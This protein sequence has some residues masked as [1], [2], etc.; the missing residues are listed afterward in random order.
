MHVYIKMVDQ[1]TPVRLTKDPA[2]EGFPAWSPDGK[3]LAFLRKTSD[4]PLESAII[5]IPAIGGFERDLGRIHVASK[6]AWSPDGKWIAIADSSVVGARSAI[7]LVSPDSGDRRAITSPP[8]DN[9]DANIWS[10]Q[11][12]VAGKPD[13]RPLIASARVEANPQYSPNG[14]RIAFASDRSGNSEI[15]ISDSDGNN[16]VQITNV[17]KGITGTPRWAPDGRRLVF[18]S[19]SGR[20]QLYT[21]SV[22]G[23]RPQ[24]LT[25][26]ESESNIPAYSHD[27]N[28]IYFTSPRSGRPEVWKVPSSSGDAVQVTH[29]GGYV[30]FE[31][32]D[33]KWLYYTKSDSRSALWK[34]STTGGEE[35]QVVPAIEQRAFFVVRRGVYFM[36]PVAA[37]PGASLNFYDFDSGATKALFTIDRSVLWGIAVAPDERA[38]I[39]T[40]IDQSGSDLMMIENFR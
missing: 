4:Q 33:G 28:W 39:W 30:V 3:W 23:G 31:S 34:L 2:V 8:T 11:F 18:D 20:W 24:Q 26:G 10:A 29:Q 38:V 36:A 7:Y 5:L 19:D 17:G 40:Q 13:I 32:L 21:V 25:Q 35:S 6:P 16:A 14:K 9:F 1:A 22:G 15:W 27:G 37:G 12:D